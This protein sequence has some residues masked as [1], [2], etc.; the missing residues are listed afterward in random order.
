MFNIVYHTFFS[1]HFSCLHLFT[2]YHIR[3]RID[4]RARGREDDPLLCLSD[5][6][7]R[8]MARLPYL[9]EPFTAIHATS[10]VTNYSKSFLYIFFTSCYLLNT[11]L[12]YLRL[13]YH[14]LFDML[15][16]KTYFFN[17]FSLLF[18]QPF[19]LTTTM[20]C[21]KITIFNML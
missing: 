11:V 7:A 2:T 4:K 9:G 3:W 18:P 19:T 1:L 17:S 14:D 15:Y 20:A 13:C 6:V 21:C 10:A 8:K 12:C 16:Y 5:T